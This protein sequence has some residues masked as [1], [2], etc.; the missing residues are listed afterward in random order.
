MMIM[1]P[2]ICL[3]KMRTSITIMILEAVPVMIGMGY[4]PVVN[5]FLALEIPVLLRSQDLIFVIRMYRDLLL[6]LNPL[7]RHPV[8]QGLS[9]WETRA[10]WATRLWGPVTRGAWRTPCL[11]CNFIMTN[12]LAIK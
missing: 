7:D 3:M 9:L 4:Y 10:E 5:P 11:E 6:K 1:E 12:H 8:R 2:C